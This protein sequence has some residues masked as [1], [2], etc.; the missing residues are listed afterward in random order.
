MATSCST[1]SSAVR[2]VPSGS[3]SLGVDAGTAV[4]LEVVVKDV[5]AEAQV[6]HG[7]GDPQR[8]LLCLERVWGVKVDCAVDIAR[9]VSTVLLV[10]AFAALL[11]SCGGSSDAALTA[12][13][14][15]PRKRPSRMLR[16]RSRFAARL[17]SR[18]ATRRTH[19]SGCS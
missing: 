18:I 1:V 7:V 13:T 5:G 4:G 6:G 11:T 12:A 19:A 15:A 2:Y 14:P 8:V 9:Q 3:W 16:I 10:G 17:A